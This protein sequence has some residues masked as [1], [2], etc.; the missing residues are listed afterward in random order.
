MDS[1]FYDIPFEMIFFPV[2]FDI[3]RRKS[4]LKEDIHLLQ[5]INHLLQKNKFIC[6]RRYSSVTTSS[7][8][9]DSFLGETGYLEGV[10]GTDR[11]EEGEMGY[12]Q[13]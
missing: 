3:A 12:K 1:L 2:P 13:L 4:H 6:N 11:W 8:A 5:K 7:A 9:E 10:G